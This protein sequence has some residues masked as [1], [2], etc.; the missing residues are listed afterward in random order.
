MRAKQARVECEKTS[1]V[2]TTTRKWNG[3]DSNCI[4]MAVKNRIIKSTLSAI[5]RVTLDAA[6]E[7]SNIQGRGAKKQKGTGLP[8]LHHRDHLH[9]E[10]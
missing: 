7:Y 3:A 8:V 4:K 9:A 6:I 10:R 5:R 1:T 2:W